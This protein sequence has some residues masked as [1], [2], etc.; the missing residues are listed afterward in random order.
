MLGFRPRWRSLFIGINR[1][2]AS[3]EKN[4][5]YGKIN[6]RPTS[7]SDVNSNPG[8]TQRSN[9]GSIPGK[10]RPQRGGVNC[11]GQRLRVEKMANIRHGFGREC[12]LGFYGKHN[13]KNRKGS[14]R[15][16]T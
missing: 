6:V 10:H 3:A 9:K 16:V 13:S 14:C 11:N 7:S 12:L 2:E 8:Q 4:V 15:D 5:P 1:L